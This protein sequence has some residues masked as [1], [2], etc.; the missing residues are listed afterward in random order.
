M[1]KKYGDDLHDLLEL[2]AVEGSHSMQSATEMEVRLGD[3]ICR[4]GGR[5]ENSKLGNLLP[6][7]KWPVFSQGMPGG[8]G[9]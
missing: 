9:D 2:K 8:G 7:L 5:G 6:W 1:G 3:Y 4:R